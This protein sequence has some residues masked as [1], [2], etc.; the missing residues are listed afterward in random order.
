VVFV[1]PRSL[2]YTSSG[3]LSRAA[4]KASYL[5]GDRRLSCSAPLVLSDEEAGTMPLAASAGG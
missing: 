2:T 5:S 1:P 3:K 4:A